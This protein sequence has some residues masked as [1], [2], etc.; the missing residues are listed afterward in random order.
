MRHCHGRLVGEARYL[1]QTLVSGKGF[2]TA[3]IGR[4]ERAPPLGCSIEI[5]RGMSVGMSVGMYVSV[6]VQKA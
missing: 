6:V 2:N 3:I 5:S 1:Y 4:A